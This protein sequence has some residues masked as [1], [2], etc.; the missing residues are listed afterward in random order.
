MQCNG[1]QLVVHAQ[2]PTRVHA[3]TLRQCGR[4]TG[5]VHY[6]I[7]LPGPVRGDKITATLTDGVLTIHARKPRPCPTVYIVDADT[8][9]GYLP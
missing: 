8:T 6:A 7:N 2:I 9:D 3:G 4:R 1:Q 5:P